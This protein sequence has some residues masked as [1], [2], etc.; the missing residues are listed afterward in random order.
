MDLLSGQIEP[1]SRTI[2]G[3]PKVIVSRAPLVGSDAP[4]HNVEGSHLGSSSTPSQLCAD[5]V[6]D[7]GTSF[8]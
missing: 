3:G 5:Q 8:R 2:E 7:K 6:E 4:G 1:P